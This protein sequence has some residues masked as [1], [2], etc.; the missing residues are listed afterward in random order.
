MAN[1]NCDAC[2]ELR[3]VDP[4][5]MINGLGDTECASLQNDTGLVT[6][7]GNTDCE[8]LNDMNDCLVGNMATEVDAY[9]VCDWK[10]FMKKF[11][12]NLW[13]TLKGIICAIC[14]IWTNVHNLWSRIA[15]INQSI[16]IINNEIADMPKDI[17]FADVSKVATIRPGYPA[18]DVNR[19]NI[20]AARTDGYV[21]VGIVGWNLSNHGESTG[22]SH[23]YPFKAKL[24]G[25]DVSMQLTNLTEENKSVEIEATV[26]YVKS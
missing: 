16:T 26:L 10:S 1:L 11:I 24:M 4:M 13:T 18:G 7:S 15:N 21:P 25:T 14:G 17:M 20:A 23:I 2:E 19:I 22:V 8:D 5:L 6:T 9:D 12:P 3:Q